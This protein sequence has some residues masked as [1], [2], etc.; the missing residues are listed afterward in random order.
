[1]KK[2]L[3]TYWPFARASVQQDLLTYPIETIMYFFGT[4]IGMF[5]VYYIWK[6]IYSTGQ[7]TL[8]E[9][10]TFHEMIAYVVVSF[11]TIQIINNGTVWIIANDIRE[12]T[13]IMNLI[14]PIHYHL[15]IFFEII[16]MVLFIT[17]IILLPITIVLNLVLSLNHYVYIPFFIFSLL[18]GVVIGFL[19]DFIFG[20]MA[21]YIHNIW[22]IG[23]GKAAL[24]RLLSGGLIPLVFF[25]KVVQQVFEFLPFK[26]MVFTPVMILLG[27]YSPREMVIVFLQQLFWIVILM[28]VNYIVWKK[29][30][31][32]LT[33]QGG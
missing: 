30:V 18:M 3:N 23:F 32:R 9:G 14:K 8:I 2:I 6:V 26:S 1:M 28:I 10:F 5:V 7:S 11:L 20:M 21:F 24:V 31:H 19:F 12:G 16:G 17:F 22:G 33:I 25:P 27:K 15:R 4:T 13:I 29:A